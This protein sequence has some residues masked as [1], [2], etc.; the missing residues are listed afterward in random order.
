MSFPGKEA[1]VSQVISLTFECVNCGRTRLKKPSDLRRFGIGDATRLA[2]VSA[3]LFCQGCREAGD[4]DRNITVRAAFAREL[5]RERAEA[6]R[7][8][9]REVL[10][11]ARRAK[12]A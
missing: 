12:G 1:V 10:Y 11:S 5:D 9:D 7:I 6:R 2:D 3:R 8:R 4:P